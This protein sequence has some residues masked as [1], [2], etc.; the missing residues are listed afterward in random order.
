MPSVL[1]IGILLFTLLLTGLA[2]W[3]KPASGQS[4][5]PPPTPA[6]AGEGRHLAIYVRY[7]YRYEAPKEKSYE[8]PPRMRNLLEE[9]LVREIS[10]PG[11]RLELLAFTEGPLLTQ[12]ARLRGEPWLRAIDFGIDDVILVEATFRLTLSDQGGA[13]DLFGVVKYLNVA[14]NQVV[15]QRP[16]SLREENSADSPTGFEM[17][18]LLQEEGRAYSPKDLAA[19]LLAAAERRLKARMGELVQQI[20]ATYTPQGFPTLQDPILM[21]TLWRAAEERA[22]STGEPEAASNFIRRL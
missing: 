14:E 2:A 6:P 7:R 20:T 18:Q 5:S 13:A 16:F 3:A 9:L 11:A 4:I 12:D 10:P 8:Q 21:E 19:A 22:A 17:R 1:Y 15:R